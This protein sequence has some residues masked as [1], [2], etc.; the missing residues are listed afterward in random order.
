MS[1]KLRQAIVN[2]CSW[3]VAHD[4]SIHYDQVRPT[5]NAKWKAHT[6]PIYTDCSGSTEAIFYTVGAPDP[7]GLSYSGQGNT[8]TLYANAEHLPISDLIPGDFIICFKGTETEHVY[9]VVERIPGG[10]LKLFT[11][12][13]ESTPAY[14]NLS[15][16]S[17]YWRSVGK[18][19]GCRTL[20]LSDTPDYAW[21]VLNANSVI[22][23][24][25]HPAR[26]AIRHPRMFRKYRWIRFR[27]DV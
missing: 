8:A 21:A 18:M 26:Y 3:G 24:T 12:G 25:R 10:D 22:G 9:I 27:R 17:G 16:V 4:A 19:T 20:P 2:E 13:Q 6:L 11:H 7:S 5:P 14:E 1:T 23:K 15:A